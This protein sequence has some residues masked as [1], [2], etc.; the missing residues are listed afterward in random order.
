MMITIIIVSRLRRRRSSDETDDLI[1]LKRFLVIMT[2]EIAV[3]TYQ[4]KQKGFTD[5]IVLQSL[6]INK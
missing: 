4:R 1:G 5:S 3:E 2:V 6:E